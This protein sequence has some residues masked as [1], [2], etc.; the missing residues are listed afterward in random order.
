LVVVVS[1][2]NNHQLLRFLSQR[3][4]IKACSDKISIAITAI[5]NGLTATEQKELHCSLRTRLASSPSFKLY[6]GTAN[7]GYFGGASDGLDRFL[8][9]AP[10]PDWIIVT[11]DDIYFADDFFGALTHYSCPAKTGVVAPITFVPASRIHQNPY[12]SRRPSRM[13]LEALLFLFSHPILYKLYLRV[14]SSSSRPRS[15]IADGQS[16]VIY[17]PHGACQIFHSRYFAKGGTLKHIS[18]L[19]GEENFVA[20]TCRRLDLHV[21]YEP[22]L[23]VEHHEHST[24]KDVPSK[25]H[26]QYMRDAVAALLKHYYQGKP[27]LTHSIATNQ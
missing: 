15:S 27:I 22:S 8:A 4:L 14:R 23:W 9:E 1:Y 24:M 18:F 17:A 16:R 3:A 20:E 5:A 6:T 11:N 21:R 26:L 19:Y 13:R 7:P 2:R 10:L 12:L 25:L